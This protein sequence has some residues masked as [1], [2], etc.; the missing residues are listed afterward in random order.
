MRRAAVGFIVCLGVVSLF[1]D[2]TYEGAR[3]ISGPFLATLGASGT[4]VGLI[5]G[6][7]ELIAF[8]LRYVSGI[9]ADRSR[10]Y[11]TI[12]FTGYGVN[13]AAVPLLAF[14]DSWQLAALLLMLERFGKSIRAPSRDA[15]LSHASHQIGR[16]WGFA[17]HEAM[18][19]TGAL[20][21]PLVVSAVLFT[22]GSYPAAFALLAIP[23]ACAMGALLVG[24]AL[25]P[26]PEDFEPRTRETPGV[27]L[28]RR[29]WIYSAGAA[30]LA[31]GYVD[32]SLI[33]YHAKRANLIADAWIPVLYALAMGVDA[34]AALAL[35]RWFDR[36]GKPALLA[37]AALSVLSAPLAFLGGLPGLLA[38]AVLW[39]AGMGAQE[40]VLRA[41][42]A[43][44][45]PA[46]R[47]ASA[48]GLFHAVNGVLWFCGSALLGWLYE[49]S[50]TGLSAISALTQCAA[51]AFFIRWAPTGTEDRPIT[52]G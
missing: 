26:S 32:F 43:E 5:A 23:A 50:L 39:G 11:W 30:T 46:G 35:G 47:R 8:G 22:R 37:G 51:L 42:V 31:F 13:L 14:A 27:P 19:Q 15:L 9:V 52:T 48:Y 38:A 12:L 10:R 21:G 3:G 20:T 36:A 17:L 41:A 18:D 40:S 24:R 25:Y 49:H 1:A 34:V 4:M 44:L 6:A 28:P 45:I 33:A 16:G 2:I 29:F 7:G